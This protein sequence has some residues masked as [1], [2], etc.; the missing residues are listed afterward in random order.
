MLEYEAFSP[1]LED[2]H[3]EHGYNE[4]ADRDEACGDKAGTHRHTNREPLAAWARDDKA[5][6]VK[7]G[8]R[9]GVAL[10]KL[11]LHREAAKGFAAALKASP[12]DRNL[13]R[14]YKEAKARAKTKKAKES[15]L[16]RKMFGK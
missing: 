7:V 4:H 3:E 1:F 6:R 12:Q 2:P 9:R 15:A 11:G 8:Y 16:F 14:A 10:G 5:A 13:R